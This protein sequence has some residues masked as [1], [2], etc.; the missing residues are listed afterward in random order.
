[1]RISQKNISSLSVDQFL[2]WNCPS[3]HIQLYYPLQSIFFP[4]LIQA[5]E[6]KVQVQQKIYRLYDFDVH[7]MKS[8]SS[9][10]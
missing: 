7:D 3:Y 10:V 6:H 9:H 2:Y 4:E 8:G 5:A 1:M